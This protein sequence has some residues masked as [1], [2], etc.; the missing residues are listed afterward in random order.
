MQH[1]QQPR[2][3]M[4]LSTARILS[5]YSIDQVS[6]ILQISCDEL[7]EYEIKPSDVKIETAARLLTL[8]GVPFSNV[9]F[10]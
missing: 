3:K 6:V 8:Y 7:N 10:V 4:S 9:S 1:D 5:G 2:T